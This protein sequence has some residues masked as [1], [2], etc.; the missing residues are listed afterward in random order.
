[1]NEL[2]RCR[3][4]IEAALE[5]SGGTHTFEDIVDGLRTGHL[6][7]WPAPKGCLITEIVIF[8]QKKTINVFL[9]GGELEQLSD[10][11]EDVIKWAKSQGCTAATINGRA[12]WVRAFKHLGW[13]PLHTTLVKE[14]D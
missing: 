10:M 6:Q 13:T 12:G 3:P 2:E 5:H 11:H 1:M 14:F 4:W 8:P 7:F 9:G